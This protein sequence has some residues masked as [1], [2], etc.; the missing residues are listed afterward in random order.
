MEI[1]PTLLSF[2]VLVFLCAVFIFRIRIY[3]SFGFQCK[4]VCGFW[5][6]PDSSRPAGLANKS[7]LNLVNNMR[8]VLVRLLLLELVAASCTL[9]TCSITR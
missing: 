5:F 8:L 4:W 1:V 3:F 6:I 7:L 2:L 9:P